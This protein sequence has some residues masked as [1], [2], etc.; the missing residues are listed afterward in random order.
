MRPSI[1]FLGAVCLC[2]AQT[3]CA[4]TENGG[5]HVVGNPIISESASTK[6]ASDTAS[7]PCACASSKDAKVK[8]ACKCAKPTATS[9][10]TSTSAPCKDTSG[11]CSK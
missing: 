2:F 7:A 6:M 5:G 4:A 1:L 10:S 3:G 9:T 8:A 11:T